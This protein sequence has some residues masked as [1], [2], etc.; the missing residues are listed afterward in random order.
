MEKNKCFLYFS[1]CSCDSFSPGC[2]PIGTKIAFCDT[3]GV[4][5]IAS[6][7]NQQRTLNQLLKPR[8][9][10]KLASVFVEFF[11]VRKSQFFFLHSFCCSLQFEGKTGFLKLN[12]KN[13]RYSELIRENSI[14]NCPGILSGLKKKSIDKT[15]SIKFNCVWKQWFTENWPYYTIHRGFCTRGRGKGRMRKGSKVK[16]QKSIAEWEVESKGDK[17]QR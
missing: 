15:E 14:S 6:R 4:P 10:A 11:F 5:G 9:V 8:K 12:Y 7:H 2:V 1:N 13:C 16:R 17:C 3:G